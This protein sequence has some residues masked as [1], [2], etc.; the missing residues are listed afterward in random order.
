MQRVYSE[1]VSLTC[2]RCQRC[3]MLVPLRFNVSLL[4]A[5][6]TMPCPSGYLTSHP[7]NDYAHEKIAEDTKDGRVGEEREE[8]GRKEKNRSGVEGATGREERD[9][10]VVERRGTVHDSNQTKRKRMIV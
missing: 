4:D 6:D 8:I 1:S 9:N 5:V 3:L 2:A 7:R 10:R